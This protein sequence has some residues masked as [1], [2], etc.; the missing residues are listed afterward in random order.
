MIESS[1]TRTEI[2]PM[3]KNVAG[4]EVVKIEPPKATFRTARESSVPR[5]LPLDRVCRGP[6]RR[7]L[8][9]TVYVQRRVGFEDRAEEGKTEQVIPVVVAERNRQIEFLLA[10]ASQHR[11]RVNRCR[12]RRSGDRFPPTIPRRRCCRR[13]ARSTFQAWRSSRA[14]PRNE[15]RVLPD[16]SSEAFGRLCLKKLGLQKLP[17]GGDCDLHHVCFNGRAADFLSATEANRPAVRAD[18]ASRLFV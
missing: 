7:L 4:A 14:R 10:R 17:L 12:R 8:R 9:F 3:L 5:R 18:V 2:P 6:R 15:G 11:V 13:S 1:P 16:D